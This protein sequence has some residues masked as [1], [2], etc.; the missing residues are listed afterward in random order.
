MKAKS[1]ATA[2]FGILLGGATLLP[3]QSSAASKPTI[4]APD[5][6]KLNITAMLQ[7]LQSAT[8]DAPGPLQIVAQVLQLQ[9]AQQ[10]VFGQLLE[11]RQTA[12][13]PL[14]LAIAQKQKQINALLDSGGNPAQIGI[15]LL[16]IHALQQQIAQIQQ[17]FLSNFISLLDQNQQQRLVAVG[18]AAQLQPIVPAFELLQLF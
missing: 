12:V 18:S 9:P 13:T 14:F 17:T 5:L 4:L 2:L 6:S 8:P 10:T 16:Q 15:L 11:A 3:A 7:P 1:F